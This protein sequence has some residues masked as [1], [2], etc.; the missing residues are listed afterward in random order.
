MFF[1]LLPL[2]QKET[3]ELCC[4][5]AFKCNFSLMLCLIW[6]ISE[7]SA[8]LQNERM[9][10]VL[11][12]AHLWLNIAMVFTPQSHGQNSIKN[13]CEEGSTRKKAELIYVDRL[14]VL[15]VVKQL[16]QCHTSAEITKL[17]LTNTIEHRCWPLLRAYSS[18]VSP[19]LFLP[20]LCKHGSKLTPIWQ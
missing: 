19:V 18:L 4:I 16:T 5:E 13:W 9:T 11:Q 2:R 1:P 15:R 3:I 14:S 8:V 10:Q 7:C 6:G 12:E 17:S 20:G